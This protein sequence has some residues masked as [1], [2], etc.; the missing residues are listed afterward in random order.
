MTS[1][2]LNDMER[3]AT[4]GVEEK[5]LPDRPAKLL[6]KE[7][8]GDRRR[9]VRSLAIWSAGYLGDFE[10]AVVALNDPQEKVLWS[11]YVDELRAAVARNAE[12]AGQVRAAFDKLPLYLSMYSCG[13]WCG[14]LLAPGQNHMYH[15]FE[16]LLA[17]WSR[18]ICNAWSAR[19]LE[20]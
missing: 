18:I 12:T 15:G 1:E 5:F 8:A 7:L 3:R 9:E 13:A 16:G 20:R 10:P 2:A 19:S 17:F 4:A 11:T 14:A 6:L